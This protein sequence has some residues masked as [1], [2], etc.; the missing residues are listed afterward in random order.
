MNS[1]DN[2]NNNN[3]NYN[4]NNNNNIKHFITNFQD[5]KQLDLIHSKLEPHFYNYKKINL[6]N[7]ALNQPL[8]KIWMVLE[9][10]KIF[11]HGTKVVNKG[12]ASLPMWIVLHENNKE[13]KA[14]YEFIIKLE[15][16][17][18]SL[19]VKE[20][21]NDKI[22][23]KSSLKKN[24]NFPFTLQLVLPYEIKNNE[25][26][27]NFSI[28][29][30]NNQPI[31]F[32]SIGKRVTISAYIELSEIWISNLEYGY[33]WNI[34]QMKVFPEFDFSKCLF[35]NQ[36]TDNFT[37]PN[38]ENSKNNIPKPPTR[39]RIINQK[40]QL[41]NLYRGFVPSMND[42]LSVKLRSISN[43][44]PIKEKQNKEPIRE[45]QNKEKYKKIEKNMDNCLMEIELEALLENETI[46]EEYKKILRSKKYQF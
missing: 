2:N 22:I 25:P 28:F 24:E 39:A 33:N 30:H 5:E 16:Q 10:V 23:A 17:I 27:F 35:I 38:E 15:S 34:L 7:R 29:N 21:K 42:L 41:N 12:K 43:K 3:D 6:F 11:R 40:P 46:N 20:T 37:Q 14:F 45:K 18:H 26:V 36:I 44:E 9:R 1:D 31:K 32:D 13:Q 19:I 8:Q 4:N